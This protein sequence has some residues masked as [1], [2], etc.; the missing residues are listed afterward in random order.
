MLVT[1][2]RSSSTDLDGS[3]VRVPVT[4]VAATSDQGFYPDQ[5]PG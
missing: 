2:T 4:G 3:S 5:T 1:G